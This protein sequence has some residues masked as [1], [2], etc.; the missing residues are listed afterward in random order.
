MVIHVGKKVACLSLFSS[1]YFSTN[2]HK[3]SPHKI[4]KQSKYYPTQNMSLFLP[5]NVE[6]LA[7]AA[8]LDNWNDQL[9][10]ES[11]LANVEFFKLPT[12]MENR[13]VSLD[14]HQL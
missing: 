7:P 8:N 11:S 4:S 9:D 6:P 10:A 13:S 2:T 14:Y 5:K 12:G 3:H 1:Q